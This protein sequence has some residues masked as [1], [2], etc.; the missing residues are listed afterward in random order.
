MF[1]SAGFQNYFVNQAIRYLL[2]C[3]C[4]HNQL[5]E[6]YLVGFKKMMKITIRNISTNLKE[7]AYNFFN[8]DPFSKQKIRSLKN[9]NKIG[10]KYGGWVIPTDWLDE[11][12]ICY[13]A[14]VG[15]DISF[16]LGLI[17]RY[18]C[19]VFAFDP[20]PRAIEHVKKNIVGY[21]NYFFMDIGLWDVDEKVKFYAPTN[22]DH[23]SHSIL[24]LQKTDAYFEADCKRLSS[25]M[26]LY[27]HAK[28]DLLKIDIEGAEYRVI[29]SIID[30]KLDINIICVEYDEVYHP[31]DNGSIKRIKD[32]LRG[33]RNY[34]YQIISADG[35]CNYTL[36]KK[37]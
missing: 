4:K 11:N 1:S 20:T 3:Q 9:L 15:E 31:L 25:I 23:V 29:E 32:S 22:P 5:E 10:T 30:D 8:L 33:L 2:C 12:S 7:K 18:D 27:G 16:D 26:Q 28:L 17:E 35:N 34:G 21:K 19:E 14:G 13:C 36:A 37:I 6:Y 24:N